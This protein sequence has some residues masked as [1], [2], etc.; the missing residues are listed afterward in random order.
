MFI[1]FIYR[2][3]SRTYYGKYDTDYISDDHNGLDLEVR[4]L[5]LNEINRFREK[6]GKEKLKKIKIGV[7]SFSDSYVSAIPT[8]SSKDEIEC[9]DFYHIKLGYEPGKTYIN[10]KII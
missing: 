1:T 9:F 6:S 5:L 10:G 8:D 4:Y 7:M 2:I 3:G